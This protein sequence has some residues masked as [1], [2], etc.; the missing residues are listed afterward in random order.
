MQCTIYA[1]GE[2]KW[3]TSLDRVLVLARKG[4]KL[5]LHRDE[6]NALWELPE[7]QLVRGESKEE[8]ARAALGEA[9]GEAV[10]DVS[11]LCVYTI[12]GEDGKESG[13]YCCMADVREWQDEEASKSRAFNRLPLA[14]PD[15]K[16]CAGVC[17]AQMGR[18]SFLT[19]GLKSSGSVSPHPIDRR[20]K[21]RYAC[22]RF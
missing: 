9:L 19:S 2:K 13:G 5:I 4:E 3:R 6:L 12:T 1:L 10:F 16:S 14:S 20:A 15:Q 18:P 8:T 17:T 21:R 11:L 7:K 22:R